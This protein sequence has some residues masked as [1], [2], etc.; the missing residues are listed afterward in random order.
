ML[1]GFHRKVPGVLN[2]VTKKQNLKKEIPRDI[3]LILKEMFLK[4]CYI[5]QIQQ[6]KTHTNTTKEL[7]KGSVLSH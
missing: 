7:Y 4:H 5:N 3:F 1:Q 2:L 6:R